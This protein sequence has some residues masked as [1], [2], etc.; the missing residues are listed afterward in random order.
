MSAQGST[1]GGWGNAAAKGVEGS[2]GKELIRLCR[3]GRTEIKKNES[4]HQ[5]VPWRTSSR[6]WERRKETDGLPILPSSLGKDLWATDER[7][8]VWQRGGSWKL[9]QPAQPHTSKAV[10]EM[11]NYLF[12]RKCGGKG[13]KR[14]YVKLKCSLSHSSYLVWVIV[15]AG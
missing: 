4:H 7:F 3:E 13:R 9:N 10:R 8:P 11:L 6:M 12:I 1:G 15:A 2:C 14:G 5:N